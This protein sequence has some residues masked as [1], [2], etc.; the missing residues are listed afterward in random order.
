MGFLNTWVFKW[1]DTYRTGITG[2]ARLA[3]MVA[4]EGQR[5]TKGHAGAGLAAKPGASPNRQP[6]PCPVCPAGPLPALSG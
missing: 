2:Q 4:Q 5:G 1:Q 6:G 3:G